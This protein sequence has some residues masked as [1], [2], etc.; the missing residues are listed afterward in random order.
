MNAENNIPLKN[1]PNKLITGSTMVRMLFLLLPVLM[2]STRNIA[3]KS[4]HYWH[5]LN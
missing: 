5:Y 2:V 3:S 1:F 4:I